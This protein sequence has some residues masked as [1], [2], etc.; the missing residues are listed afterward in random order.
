MGIMIGFGVTDFLGGSE[1]GIG[2]KGATVRLA[3]FGR[4][5][6]L[7]WVCRGVRKELRNSGK[8]GSY[9]L[10]ARPDLRQEPWQVAFPK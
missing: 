7:R 9:T 3:L 6:T 10:R 8:G 4:V 1:V 2:A 5:G